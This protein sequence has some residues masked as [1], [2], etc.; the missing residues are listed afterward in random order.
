MHDAS[1]DRSTLSRGYTFALLSAAFLSTTAIFIRHL[2]LDYNMPPLVLAFWRAGFVLLTVLPVMA[3][4]R[5]HLLRVSRHHLAY[6][7]LYGLL[8]S[9]FN[10]TWTLSVALNGAAVATVLAY[11]SAAFTAILGRWL[12]HERLGWGKIVAVMLCMGG[13]VL[14]AEAYDAAAWQSNPLGI[15]TGVL[16]GLGYAIYSLMGRSAAQRGLNPW[17]TL[18][19]TFGCAAL[20]LLLFNLL[21]G[22]AL[23]GSAARPQDLLWLQDAYAGWGALFL[24]AAGPTVAGFGLYNVSLSYLPSSSVNLIVTLEPA[25]TTALAYALFGERLTAVQILGSLLIIS[26]VAFLRIYEDRLTNQRK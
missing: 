16:S 8:L 11:S 13:C 4:L 5:R 24:L 7:I 22:G 12:L 19:Y 1:P 10:A 23:P 15:L 6:L 26:G 9:L 14:V 20:F 21:S 17:T 25:F 3:L 2:T 18:L